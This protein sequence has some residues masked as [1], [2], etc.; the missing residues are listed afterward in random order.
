MWT[1]GGPQAQWGGV[2]GQK[3]LHS[4]AL[5]PHPDWLSLVFQR[6]RFRGSWARLRNVPQ[7]PWEGQEGSTAS[8]GFPLCPLRTGRSHSGP[9]SGEL[10]EE[11]NQG[12]G[13][14]GG[15]TGWDGAWERG[16]GGG[17]YAKSQGPG[18]RGAS[19][20]WGP[21]VDPQPLNSARDGEPRKAG[22]GQARTGL[23]KSPLFVLISLKC[24]NLKTLNPP[25]LFLLD[26]AVPGR[27]LLLPELLTKIIPASCLK[28]LRFHRLEM[29]RIRDGWAGKQG[30]LPSQLTTTPNWG[31]P[32]SPPPA[33]YY[34][35]CLWFGQGLGWMGR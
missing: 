30:G 2:G 18:W 11:Q 9:G 12:R 10:S 27:I 29:L 16:Q 21:L 31:F 1:T 32:L 17:A 5:P 8:Q 28:T 19:P 6:T 25:P 13:R 3:K 15:Y 33:A 24:T 23:N 34:H 20:H 4:H 7:A 14:T 22:D 26:V 35:H